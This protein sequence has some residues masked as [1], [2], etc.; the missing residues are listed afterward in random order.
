MST[1]DRAV[2]RSQTKSSLLSVGRPDG[3]PFYATVDRAS[4][5]LIL[6]TSCTSIDCPVDRALSTDRPGDRPGSFWP[7][8]MPLFLL[9]YFSISVLPYSTSSISSL[10][11]AYLHC[12]VSKI[13]HPKAE[14]KNSGCSPSGTFI[15]P[16]HIANYVTI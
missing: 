10:P 9:L 5:G 1:V 3:R 8:S 11:T 13:Q 7:A 14:N 15:S 2:D 4:T 12:I 6:C 16:V